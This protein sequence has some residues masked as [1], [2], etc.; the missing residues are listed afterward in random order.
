MLDLIKYT[1]H[2][3]SES[4]DG[5]LKVGSGNAQHP[6]C[7]TQLYDPLQAPYQYLRALEDR[8]NIGHET[9]DI[10]DIIEESYML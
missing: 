9:Q 10:N 7:L 2:T 6:A 5:S 3:Y 1:N 4:Q 8:F